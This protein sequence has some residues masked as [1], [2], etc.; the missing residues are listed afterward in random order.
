MIIIILER[1]PSKNKIINFKFGIQIGINIV[2]FI[3]LGILESWNLGILE[4]WNIT[5]INHLII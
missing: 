1:F 3:Y 4:S 5:K 2:F